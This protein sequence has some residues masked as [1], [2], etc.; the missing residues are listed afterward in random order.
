[1][2]EKLS[3]N[4]AV[5]GG[6]CAGLAAAAK[7][8]ELGI[9]ATLFEASPHLGGRART[10]PWKGLQLDNGQ[11]ILLGAYEQT[12]KLLALCG[13][14]SATY[15]QR[16]PLN[17]R[18]LGKF[19]L[20]SCSR[21]PAPLHILLGFLTARGLSWSE[22]LFALRFMVWM[23]LNAFKLNQDTNLQAFLTEHNQTVNLIRC[24]WEPL[25]LAALNTPL[26]QASAQVF[27]NVLRDSFAARKSD[28]D[29]LL[30]T[31]DLSNL[32]ASPLQQYIT[33]SGSSVSVNTEITSIEPSTNKLAITTSEDNKLVFSHVIVATSPFRSANLLEKIDGMQP[34]VAN[35]R[36]LKY[37][38]IY[39]L[40]LQYAAD[41]QLDFPMTGMTGSQSQWIFDRGALYG[42]NGL[43]AI[44]IS[45]EGN[46]Q[47]MT[48]AALAET[49]IDEMAAAFPQLGKPL[50]HKVI[51]E[52]RATF[53]CVPNLARP[54]QLTPVKNLYIAG[55]YTAGDYP[56]TI[57]GAVRSGVRCAEL[58]YQQTYQ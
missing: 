58:I 19:E 24:L 32:I 11:H 47:S 46:H 27:L 6:G 33:R 50:W 16:L 9:K 22:R 15:L 1:M 52:K 57:E 28:S 29:L 8:S 3:P 48:Q 39:T 4:V 56:A 37:Q 51:A 43:M 10:V 49:V 12:L 2:G 7:L 26:N 25:C 34:I 53:S 45:A 41:T 17:L 14:D 54:D 35:I 21:L 23:Q 44:I 20:K 40:Y 36:A 55:D 30:P 5:I 18:I 42:Q 31:I 13:V 38:P